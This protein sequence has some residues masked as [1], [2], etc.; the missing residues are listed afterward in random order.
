MYPVRFS[1]AGPGPGPPTQRHAELIRDALWAHADTDGG[2]EHITVFATAGGAELVIF[3]G[4]GVADP[5]RYALALV[6][7]G[8]ESSPALRQ[9]RTITW[10]PFHVT[11]ACR[12]EHEN[13]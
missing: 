1:L 10:Q 5:D 13:L 7:R 11:D 4:A 12:R 6:D 3:L 2:V 9:W 8:R